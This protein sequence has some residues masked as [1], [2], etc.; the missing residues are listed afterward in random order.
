MAAEANVPTQGP[1]SVVF[2]QGNVLEGFVYPDDTFNIVYCSQ[3]FGHLPPLDLPLWALAEL[4]RVLKPGGI[5][6]TRDT[7]SQR[8]SPQ[9]LCLNLDRLWVRNQSRGLSNLSISKGVPGATVYSGLETRKWLAWWAAGKL[10]KGGPFRQGW[11]DAG[12]TENE[13]QQMLVAVRK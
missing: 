9:S 6:A 3:L 11:L 12:I 4:R 2:E 5:L 8:F 13:I 1:G 10:Q 7:A